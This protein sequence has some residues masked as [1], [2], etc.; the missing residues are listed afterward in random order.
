MALCRVLRTSTAMRL[1]ENSR[2][3]SATEAFLPRM[4]CA[5]RFSFCGLTRTVRSTACASLSFRVRA[6]FC[7]PILLPLGLLVGR[8]AVIG[9]GRRELAELVA[10]HVFR[11][12]DRDMLLAVVD[13][14]G[15]PH[16]LGQDR[17]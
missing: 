3:A 2:S 7:L 1:R 4:S 13:A 16:E 10:D 8:M 14:E 12:V 6:R 5:T 11:H 9:P 15:Q 17:G